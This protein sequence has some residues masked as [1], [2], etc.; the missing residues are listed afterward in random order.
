[1][2]AGSQAA[3]CRCTAWHST[4][5]QGET[6][7][8]RLTSPS[9]GEQTCTSGGVLQGETLFA[10]EDLSRLTQS[11]SPYSRKGKARL[12]F[13]S[14]SAPGTEGC[15]AMEQSWDCVYWKSAC[16]E[17]FFTP[18]FSTLLGQLPYQARSSGFTA[19]LSIS[20][21]PQLLNNAC[22]IR[23]TD[24]MK[25][26]VYVLSLWWINYFDFSFSSLAVFFWPFFMGGFQGCTEVMCDALCRLPQP[27]QCCWAGAAVG[28]MGLWGAFLFWFSPCRG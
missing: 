28:E 5:S 25:R 15:P 7:C 27:S 19:P 3:T 21:S 6:V 12:L 24:K 22:L 16:A 14:L 17:S 26:F 2:L 23:L 10:C 13:V 1:M 9:A 8:N 11:C 20:S 18:L 4:L